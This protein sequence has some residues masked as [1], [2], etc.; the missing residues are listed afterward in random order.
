M[1]VN[2]EDELEE[3]NGSRYIRIY[4]NILFEIFTIVSHIVVRG[5]VVKR[6][7]TR[8]RLQSLVETIL[9]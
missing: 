6:W 2:C 5:E 8:N 7:L 9:L 3:K 4:Y 1:F